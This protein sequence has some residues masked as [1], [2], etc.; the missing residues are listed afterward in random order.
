MA[1]GAKDKF[2]CFVDSRTSFDRIV[3]ESA[4]EGGRGKAR[5]NELMR[6]AVDKNFMRVD[7]TV[8]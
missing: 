2:R 7:V 4:V 5:N 3:V 6:V 1:A 8:H